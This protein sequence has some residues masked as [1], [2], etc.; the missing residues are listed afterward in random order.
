MAIDTNQR[1]YGAHLHMGIVRGHTAHRW[2][3]TCIISH[4]ENMHTYRHTNTTMRRGVPCDV[5]VRASVAQPV[6]STFLKLSLS[7]RTCQTQSDVALSPG[8]S[9]LMYGECTHSGVA[10][11]RIVLIPSAGAD[12]AALVCVTVAASKPVVVHS[13]IHIQRRTVTQP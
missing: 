9:Q 11:T 5:C 1:R 6:R 2:T 3:G 7:L 12:E 4:R 8:S 10:G 13:T